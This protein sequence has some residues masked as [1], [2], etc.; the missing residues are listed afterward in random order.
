MFWAK[1]G[2]GM[3]DEKEST[4]RGLALK[5]SIVSGMTLVSRILGVA[6]DIVFARY[7][8]PGILLDAFLVAQRIPNMLR[9]FFAEGAFSAGFVPVMARYRENHSEEEARE[10][11]DA[12][13][14]TFGIILFVVTLIGVIASPL[15]VIAVAPGFIGDGGDFDLAAFYVS[16]PVFHF[17]DGLRRRRTQYLRPFRDSRVYPGHSQCRV[18]CS[19]SLAFA[20]AGAADHGARLRN[21]RRRPAA[22]ASSDSSPGPDQGISTTEVAP[23]E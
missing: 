6:R 20:N 21:F 18:D 7:F 12:M 5:A 22:V 13:A 8:G 14:G 2:A 19:G 11:I 1:L 10:Y 23:E 3:K 9:R 16:V 15:L 4:G 17:V